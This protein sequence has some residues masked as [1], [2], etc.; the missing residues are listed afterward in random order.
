MRHQIVADGL[1]RP[2]N[3]Q[4]AGYDMPPMEWHRILRD[5]SLAK[6][7]GNNNRDDD[8]RQR[9]DPLILDCRNKYET[10]VGRF[11]GAEPLNTENFRDTWDILKEKLK[12]SP[13]DKP[14]MTYCTGV[15][16]N[17]IHAFLKNL[18]C[19]LEFPSQ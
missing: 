6:L 7:A 5:R 8:E 15:S 10:S 12:V 19:S 11:D 18:S 1:D 2:L 4:S 16:L 14:I 3:W 9:D 17:H 13:K